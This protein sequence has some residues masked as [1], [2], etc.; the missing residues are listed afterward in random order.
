MRKGKREREAG[1]RHR[2]ARIW[3]GQWGAEAA[4]LKL[5]RKHMSRLSKHLFVA[6]SRKTGGERA[7]VSARRSLPTQ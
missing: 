4:P 7:L 6:D 3:L 5:G 1:K 2:R